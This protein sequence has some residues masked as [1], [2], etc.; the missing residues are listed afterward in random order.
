VAK[1]HCEAELLREAED[2]P[3]LQLSTLSLWFSSAF[4]V[5][6]TFLTAITATFQKRILQSLVLSKFVDTNTESIRKNNWNRL[7]IK[8]SV[9]NSKA[10]VVEELKTQSKL[11]ERTLQK[12]DCSET[13]LTGESGFT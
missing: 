5:A 2:E 4:A 11:K 13:T 3:I 7:L 12:I 10:F 6:V 1:R 9:V 8:S